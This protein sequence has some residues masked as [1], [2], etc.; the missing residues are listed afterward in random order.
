MKWT[1][2]WGILFFSI[3]LIFSCSQKKNKRI[4]NDLP[5]Q[6]TEKKISISSIGGIQ[7]TRSYSEIQSM[8]DQKKIDE[9]IKKRDKSNLYYRDSRSDSVL[10]PLFQNLGVVKGD[11][12]LLS[13]FKFSNRPQT[14]IKSFSGKE[15][16]FHLQKDTTGNNQDRIIAFYDGDSS[17]AR[18]TF[19]QR[20]KYVFLDVIPGGNKE[21]VVLTEDYLMNTDIYT[22]EVFEIK[23][24]DQ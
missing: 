11:E 4:E 16:K 18:P 23:T 15:I 9:F 7:F 21:L 19:H 6:K 3:L 10:K 12:L 8:T 13:K 5:A 17:Q 22:F 1:F 20:I 14:V 24:K 2:I